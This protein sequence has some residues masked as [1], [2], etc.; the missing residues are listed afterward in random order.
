MEILPSGDT[1]CTEMP[2][3]VT[4]RVVWFS[5][6]SPSKGVTLNGDWLA[7]FVLIFVSIGF[8]KSFAPVF[9]SP[10]KPIIKSSALE[11]VA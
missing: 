3:G 6:E 8:E 5:E 1:C 2:E 7:P 11:S 10:L 4:P 9:Y